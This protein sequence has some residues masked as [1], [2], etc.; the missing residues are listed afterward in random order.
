MSVLPW[1]SVSSLIS[2]Q[3]SLR[4][5][6]TNEKLQRLCFGPGAWTRPRS[7]RNCVCAEH[8]ANGSKEGDGVVLRDDAGLLQR[9]FLQHEDEAR[10]ERPRGKRGMLLLLRG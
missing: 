7:F 5:E 4:Q 2:G 3:R 8:F 1:V 10:R 9:R 6:N